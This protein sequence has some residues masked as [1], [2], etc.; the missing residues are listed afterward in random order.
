[1]ILMTRLTFIDLFAGIGGMRL[2]FTQAGA[3]CVFSSEWNKFAQM[4]YEANFLEKPLGDITKI[5]N[6]E[7]PD[8]D[9]LLA[10]FPCH[11]FS[12]AGVSKHN[13]LGINHGFNHPTQGNLF[14][15]IVRILADKKPKA[16]LLENFKNLQSHDKGRTFKIIHKVLDDLGYYIYYKVIDL[17]L[18]ILCRSIVK[19]FSLL[20]LENL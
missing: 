10:G 19:E 14:F 18:F 15:E 11:P 13:A 1:M 5:S 4:T 6:S 20:N 7:I 3:E 12:I 9:I 17:I 2:G 8:H 16:F